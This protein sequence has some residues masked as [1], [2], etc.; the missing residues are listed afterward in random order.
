MPIYDELPLAWEQTTVDQIADIV[1][2][3]TPNASDE[4]N[5]SEDG[6]PWITPADLT[7]YKLPT[8]SRGRRCLSLKGLEQSS[9]KLLPAGSVLFSS[10]APIG[11]CVVAANQIATN[12]GFKNL[13]LRGGIEPQFIRHYLLASKAYAESLASGT[14]FPELSAA[15]MKQL[16][17]PLPPLPEQRRIVARIEALQARSQ[18]A[19]EALEAVGPL[20]EQFRQSVLAAAFRGDLT[21]DW[22]AKYPNTEPARDLLDRIRQERRQKWEA[23]NPKKKYVEPEPVDESDLPE[24]PEGWSLASLD[25]IAFRITYGI[26]VRPGYVDDGVPIISAKEIR[27]GFVNHQGANRISREDYESLRDKCKILNGDILFSKTGSI[28]HVARV[29]EQINL[30]SSQNIAVISPVIES[31][32]LET[33]LRAPFIQQLAVSKLKTTAIPDLN[34]GDLARFPIPIPPFLEQVQIIKQVRLVNRIRE[35]QLTTLENSLHELT[36][37]NQS[38]LAKAFRGELVPQ[39]PNDE[40]ASVLLVRIRAEREAGAGVKASRKPRQSRSK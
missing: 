31:E 33:A 3:G 28:G 14:T 11:Y 19:R 16:E 36:A 39:D 34:L 25:E 38:I 30:C 13:I 27:N 8:I 20:L 22:R 6:V 40:P 35:K 7:G 18:K 37:I 17:L 1:A 10:R 29:C 12:Q 23:A 4:S 26:T 15:R 24:L 21:A 5:F 32:Y 9:A 2:G